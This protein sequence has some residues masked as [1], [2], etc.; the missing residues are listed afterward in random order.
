MTTQT[1]SS[2]WEAFIGLIR[3]WL[4][5]LGVNSELFNEIASDESLP[6]P[7]R[8]L[9]TGVLVYL[10]WSRD[11][12]PDRY[13]FIGLIDD[14]LVMII[15]LTLIVA[16]IPEERR[17]YYRQKYEAV[18]R[19][20]EYEQIVS[21]TLGVLWQRLARFV[22]GLRDRRYKGLTLEQ[23][24]QSPALREELFDQTMIRI[25]DMGRDPATL[26]KGQRQ[27]PPPE[28]VI[29]LLTSGLA[30]ERQGEGEESDSE[31]SSASKRK[32]LPGGVKTKHKPE[33][34]A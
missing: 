15:A 19:I 27:L 3:N 11:I 18:G 28:Q 5:D 33:S 7:A 31:A 9:A 25:A 23:V 10:S 14:V 20:A 4:E 17:K 8:T 6:F 12:I 1:Q 22:E 29:G 21:Q 16:L 34:S 24:T 30:R 32:Q 2:G 26:D 13:W